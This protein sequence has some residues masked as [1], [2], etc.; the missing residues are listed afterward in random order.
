[1]DVWSYE[2]EAVC[3]L[4]HIQ[5]HAARVLSNKPQNG[6]GVYKPSSSSSYAYIN[7][8][9]SA[10]CKQR[11]TW[12]FSKNIRLLLFPLMMIIIIVV[13]FFSSSSFICTELPNVECAYRVRE[14]RL[15]CICAR[16]KCCLKLSSVT[17]NSN[18]YKKKETFRLLLL[19]LLLL[20][21]QPNE[22]TVRL[23]CRSLSLSL[24]A[25]WAFRSF[26]IRS[27]AVFLLIFAG[28]PR[29]SN[30]IHIKKYAAAQLN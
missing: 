12:A 14:T 5:P 2:S 10:K 29:E 25:V 17:N 28:E 18:I 26:Y 6:I 16:C 11:R 21:R 7:F 23:L 3:K 13:F 20:Q 22:F 4:R 19:F 15:R 30:K 8:L 1:M 27:T 24:L 9:H